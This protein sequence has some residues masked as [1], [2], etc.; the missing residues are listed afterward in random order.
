KTTATGISVEKMNKTVES[1][2]H[3]ALQCNGVES[4]LNAKKAEEIFSEGFLKELEEQ[5]KP[6]TRF[7]LLVKMLQKEIREYGKTNGLKAREFSER[8]KEIVERYNN[9]DHLTF[10]GE[11]ATD[12]INDVIALATKVQED[13]VSFQK[14]GITFEEKA[15]YDILQSQREKHKFE[16]SEEKMIKLAREIKTLIEYV[17]TANWLD[18]NNLRNQ[19][20]FDLTALLYENGYPPDW[21]RE[22]FEKVIEQVENYK[23]YQ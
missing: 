23:K 19:V 17:P 21:N 3:A 2:V 7:Q 22:V 15:F 18:N 13:R 14:L 9:R 4:V 1:M 8:L 6:N 20:Q 16:Y 5:V 11:V 12:V 10:A